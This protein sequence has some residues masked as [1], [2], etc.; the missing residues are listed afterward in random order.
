MHTIPKFSRK[1][2]VKGLPKIKFEKDLVCDACV[3]GNHSKSSFQSKNLIST[4]RTLE[5]LL[6]D[7][8]GPSETLS[9]ME[10]LTVL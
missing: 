5:F 1:D 10:K 3:K 6:I 8:L 4:I 9:L 2:L 7:L